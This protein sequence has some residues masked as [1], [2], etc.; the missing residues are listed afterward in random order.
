M[1]DCRKLGVKTVI[2]YVIMFHQHSNLKAACSYLIIEK[3]NCISNQHTIYKHFCFLQRLFS[4][5]LPES[6]FQ[7]QTACISSTQVQLENQH[8]ILVCSTVFTSTVMPCSICWNTLTTTFHKVTYRYNSKV[9]WTKIE[10]SH[11]KKNA[12]S[13]TQ[14][15]HQH[16][17]V[18]LPV[19]LPSCRFTRPKSVRSRMLVSYPTLHSC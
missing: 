17:S 16:F 5:W 8:N 15:L 10:L 14:K 18:V 2:H 7:P 13:D 3:K 12:M 4:I 9:A 1:P 19:K 11:M 6:L